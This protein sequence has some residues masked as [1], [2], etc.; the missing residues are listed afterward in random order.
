MR[1]QFVL[2]E[3]KRTFLFFIFCLSFILPG[4]R[5]QAQSAEELNQQAVRYINSAN[6]DTA[7]QLLSQALKLKENAGSYYLTGHVELIEN[8]WQEAV[9]DGEKA[10]SIDP[11]LSYVYPDLYYAYTKLDDWRKAQAILDKMSQADPKGAPERAAAV[12]KGLDSQTKSWLF[13]IVF[14]AVLA[15]LFFRPIYKPAAE[16]EY[17]NDAGE[18]R[19]TEILLLAS[20]LSCIFFVLFFSLSAWIWSFNPHYPLAD[21]TPPIRAYIFER[22]GI[23]SFTLYLLLLLV[24]A[25]TLAASG[26]LLKLRR[27][28]SVYQGF[29]AVLL[30][31][32]AFYFFKVGFFPPLPVFAEAGSLQFPKVLGCLAVL[33]IGG[34]LLYDKFGWLVKGVMVLFMAFAGFIMVYP[35]S[36]PDLSFVMY[37]ALRLMH[38]FKVSEIYFQYDIFLSLLAVLWLKLNNSLASFAYLGQFSYF[39]FFIASFFFADKYFKSKGLSVL[40]IIALVL[41]RYYGPEEQ[42]V[43]IFQVSPLRLDLWIIPLIIAYWKGVH[44]WLVG[45]AV[46]LLVLFHRNLGLI[47][48][49]SY[50]EVLFAV[51]LLDILSALKDKQ[52]GGTVS[53]VISRH[54]RAN[55]VSIGLIVASVALCFILFK[56]MFSKSALIYRELGIGMLPIGRHSFYWYVPVLLSCLTALLY[57]FRNKLGERYTATSLFLVLLAVGESMYFFG[58]SHENNIL[59]ISGILILA[60]FV[61]FDVLMYLSPTAAV[62]AVPQGKGKQ[63]T[64]KKSFV[65][66][67]KV[68]VV[69][70]LV[71]IFLTG[72]FYSGRISEKADMQLS[73]LQQSQLVVPLMEIPV[74]TAAVR[75]VT[76]GSD[77]V[78]FLDFNID[79]Y[80]YYYGNYV[81]QGYYNPLE[82]WVFKKDLRAFLQNLL[83]KGY[84][85][86]YYDRNFNNFD[87]YLPYLDY[88]QSYKVNNTVSVKKEK[89]PFLLP[90]TLPS[91]FHIA[92]KDMLAPG[93]IQ[94]AGV[95]IAENFTIEAVIRPV[96]PQVANAT[97]LSNL[98]EG[99]G[100]CLQQFESNQS[101]YKFIVGDGKQFLT[102]PIQLDA[103]MW[104]YLVISGNDQVLK[105]YDNGKLINT[106]NTG[107]KLVANSGAAL[108]IGNFAAQTAPFRGNI[109]EVNI[110]N[111]NL[112]DD[113]IARNAEKVAAAIGR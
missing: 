12:E 90:E 58:R 73:N 86:V 95:T 63:P 67:G 109:R 29:S 79:F 34:Y 68:Y 56:E 80:Y 110:S 59:N 74:D 101:Q 16:K 57:Y 52:A 71:F 11:S 111:G 4:N 27:N 99:K 72:Y 46:G 102:T 40:F 69:L 55:A 9:R 92:T 8:Q 88:D 35:A 54:I 81:P 36:L 31:V 106:V 6:Y 75:K 87:D 47:Y 105:I 14:I 53:S 41:I 84:Y 3:M 62:D 28:K 78:F 33:S 98:A 113:I 61:L 103:N 83:D 51:L 89:V 5:L 77:K 30:L 100:V 38:G 49:G 13:V 76:F 97:I 65:P 17:F 2:Q 96:G 66:G 48:L 82:A 26:L 108:S 15:G 94:R 24:I 45:L 25:A 18:M 7:L 85:L 93:G 107:R 104:H 112:G 19:F 91:A 44:H 50:V 42:S 70:P 1:K 21:F 43:S 32:S 22:D 23:E 10:I 64:A 60:L 20:S 37:P 39:L